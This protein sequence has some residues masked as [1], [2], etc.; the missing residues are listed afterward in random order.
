MS[1]KRSN[2]L[3][4]FHVWLL[5]RH[6]IPTSFFHLLGNPIALG[7]S[8]SW[9]Q[10][11]SQYH[12]S[13][14]KT[15]NQ[16]PCAIRTEDV[17]PL[18]AFDKPAWSSKVK[19]LVPLNSP[20][21]GCMVQH[22]AMTEMLL[23]TL[24]F[25]HVQSHTKLPNSAFFHACFTSLLLPFTKASTGHSHISYPKFIVDCCLIVLCPCCICHVLCIKIKMNLSLIH[26]SL[27]CW[28]SW[29]FIKLHLQQHMNLFIWLVLLI[30][31]RLKK[32]IVCLQFS[33]VVTW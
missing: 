28:N 21:V 9:L 26:S 22:H 1:T 15:S 23:M 14:Q 31:S 17:L 16:W 13:K 2:E 4:T 30:E 19:N 3:I 8:Q 12:L 32:V 33:N 6:I 11:C 25:C 10:L 7:W 27:T 24:F 18:M 5:L 29:V 20:G